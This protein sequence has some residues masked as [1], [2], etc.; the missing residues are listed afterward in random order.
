[1][2][3]NLEDYLCKYVQSQTELLKGCLLAALKNKD[4]YFSLLDESLGTRVQSVDLALCD[5]LT[6]AG[7]FRDEIKLTRDGRNRYKL[8]HLTEAG[9]EIA[10][11]AKKDG[12]NG[13]IP[14]SEQTL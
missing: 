4:N 2:V 12:Y 1:M 11:Q 3:Q 13:R 9:R 7:L 10:E 14:Q 5:F 8:Y 6:S